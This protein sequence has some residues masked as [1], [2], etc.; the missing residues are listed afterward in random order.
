VKK[1]ED[2]NMDVIKSETQDGSYVKN[3]IIKLRIDE[4]ATALFSSDKDASKIIT[5]LD[6]Y[7]I[8]PRE[9]YES[10]IRLQEVAVRPPAG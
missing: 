4:K 10:L 6:G 7:A 9:E 3:C 8:V 2:F 5:K 1:I